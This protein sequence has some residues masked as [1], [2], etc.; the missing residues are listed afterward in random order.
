[1]KYLYKYPQRGVSVR[2]ARRTRTA[3][4]AAASP[5]TNCS[6]PASSTTTATSTSSSS[7]RRPRRKICCAGSRVV[8]RGRQPAPLDLLPTVWFRNTWSWGRD[9]G[10]TPPRLRRGAPDRG[11]RLDRARRTA[12]SD[13]RSL[14]AEGSP[15]LLFVENETNRASV[16]GAMAERPLRQRRHQRLRRPRPARRGEPRGRRHQ[17]RGAVSRGRE[18]GRDAR[19]PAAALGRDRPTAAWAR[20]SIAC[21]RRGMR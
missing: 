6:T 21:S 9:S 20:I 8:N 14:A 4:A 15:Q 13:A 3:D 17:G 10:P 2:R 16:F 7:T 1:M 18:P 19:D 12:C 5:S 11:R